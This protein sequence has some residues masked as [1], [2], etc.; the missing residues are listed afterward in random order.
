MKR[1]RRSQQARIHQAGEAELDFGNPEL[2]GESAKKAAP[3]AE[4]LD[5]EQEHREMDEQR[6]PGELETE[7]RHELPG[8][9]HRREVGCNIGP[10]C[11]LAT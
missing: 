5:P 6:K 4:E 8:S 3:N 10:K 7:G 9:F 2:H 11:C 1:R